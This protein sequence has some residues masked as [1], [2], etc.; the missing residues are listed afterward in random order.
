ML[1]KTLRAFGAATVALSMSATLVLAGNPSTIGQ[2]SAECGDSNATVRPT[3]F[4]TD[5]FLNVAEVN[6]A[7][8]DATGGLASGN[9]SVVSQYDVACYQLTQHQP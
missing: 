3:G 1:R 8:P 4:L 5:S 9:G 7:N 6:Y 2:P